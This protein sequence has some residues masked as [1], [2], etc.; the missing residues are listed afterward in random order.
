MSNLKKKL[1]IKIEHKDPKIEAQGV[2]AVKNLIKTIGKLT[3]EK[4]EIGEVN[5]T[6]LI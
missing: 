4:I 6:P 5:D 1:Y 2:K 3:G